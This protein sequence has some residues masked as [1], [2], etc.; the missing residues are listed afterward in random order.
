MLIYI[1]ETIGSHCKATGLTNDEKQLFSDLASSH[2]QGDCLLSGDLS[3]IECLMNSLGDMQSSVYNHIRNNHSAIRSIVEIVEVV[4]VLS[5]NQQPKLPPFFK[6]K[7]RTVEVKDALNYRLHLQCSLV[8]EN[9]EDCSFYELVSKRFMFYNK[10]KGLNISFR[11]ELG[12]GDTINTVF[13]KCVEEDKVLTLCLVDG[14]IK[15][16]STKQY[17]ESPA[18]GV[19]V[20]KLETTYNRIKKYPVNSLCELY[21]LPVHEIENLIPFSVLESIAKTAV[22]S[23]ADGVKYLRKLM[24]NQLT[25]AI[26]YYDFKNGGNKVKDDPSVTYWIEIAEKI[27]DDTFPILCSKILEKAVA[28]LQ[29]NTSDMA[30]DITHTCID[31]YLLPLWDEIGLTVFSWGCASPPIRT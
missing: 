21:C 3:S 22:P 29:G 17:P 31:S 13:K 12:G 27:G 6:G 19:T 14:D 25:D 16:G 24:D 20:K 18:R 1:D 15:Y 11:H 7:Y 5:Y 8:A 10:L 28:V 23:M 9:L 4:I 30:N 2:R 26:L